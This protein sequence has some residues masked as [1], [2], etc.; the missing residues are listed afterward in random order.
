MRTTFL[1]VLAALVGCTEP[2]GGPSDVAEPDDAGRDESTTC[3]GS[4]DCPA[5]SNGLDDDGDTL[6]DYPLDPG[7]SRRE[8]DDESEPAAPAACANDVDDDGDTPTDYPAD[9]GCADE[10]DDDETD[11]PPPAC[12]NAADDDGDTLTD[13]PADPG[14]ADARDD[15]ETDLCPAAGCPACSNGLDDDGDT[16]TDYPSDPECSSAADEDERCLLVESFD[17]EWP[18]PW[19]DEGGMAPFMSSR[20][21][22]AA[23][24]GPLGLFN[25]MMPLF[26]PTVTTGAAG[27]TVSMWV[28]TL[29]DSNTIHA[30][31][32]AYGAT[33]SYA[34]LV[35]VDDLLAVQENPR[36]VDP[37]LLA[38]TTAPIEL[39]VWYRLEVAFL[40]GG[41]VECRVYAEGG[42]APLASIS[43]TFTVPLAGPIG[44]RGMPLAAMDTVEVCR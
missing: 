27:E 8:D 9:P 11:P 20:R 35:T 23:H 7:C 1:L 29:G 14:C 28:R 3:P 38:Q 31:H 39:L 21:G 41:V 24:D 15:D 16:R 25:A 33:G 13:Y 19:V 22:A 26:N 10:E 12:S 5:C 30:L 42:G 4:P 37:T 40:D 43:H 36:G 32:F 2:A 6:T 44:I 17:E 34:C 18:G